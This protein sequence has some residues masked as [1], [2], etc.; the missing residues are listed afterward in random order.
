MSAFLSYVLAASVRSAIPLTLAGLG[1]V[2]SERAGVMNLALEGQM[3]MGAFFGVVVS[4]YTGSPWLGL[5]GAMMAGVLL[6]V[7]M[8]YL[9]ITLCSNQIVVATAV[10]IVAVGITGYGLK[11]FN[12]SAGAGGI[13]VVP[14]FS[15]VSIPVLSE[16]PVVG[17]LLFSY[18]P[19]VYLTLVLIVAVHF[20]LNHTKL[21]LVHRSIGETPMVA[22]TLGIHVNRIRYGAVLTCG[23]LCGAGGA[24]MSLSNLNQFQDGMISGRG[25]I[26]FAAVIFGRWTPIGTFLAALFFGFTDAFQL[27]MQSTQLDISYHLLQIIP[28]LCTVIALAAVIGKS[29]A[30]ASDGVPYR[31][32]NS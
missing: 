31:K 32:E 24:F 8:A 7:I 2:I 9:S 4:F 28:Y 30:P 26:A 5:L 20:Y 12:T 11:L 27:R 29:V 21:G 1:G 19:M 16:L 10:N 17:S 14:S 25:F 6:S 23:A 3:L 18:K 15:Y 13:V 22:D